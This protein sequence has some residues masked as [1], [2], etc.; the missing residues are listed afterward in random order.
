[1]G[2]TAALWEATT[3]EAAKVEAEKLAVSAVG[4]TSSVR[5]VDPVPR[6]CSTDAA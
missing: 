6:S 4:D 2:S 5:T 1:M 3:T